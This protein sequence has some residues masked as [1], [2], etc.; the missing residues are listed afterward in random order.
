MSA[1]GDSPSVTHDTRP[2]NKLRISRFYILKPNS[3]QRIPITL[4]TCQNSEIHINPFRSLERNKSIAFSKAA[5][6]IQN[7]AGFTFVANLTND[8]VKLHRNTPIGTVV[9]ESQNSSP[10]S[11]FHSSVPKQPKDTNVVTSPS[12]SHSFYLSHPLISFNADVC[13]SRAENSQN[14]NQPKKDTQIVPPQTDNN[15]TQTE[16]V[17]QSSCSSQTTLVVHD[18]SCQTQTSPLV[19]LR[20]PNLCTQGTQSDITGSVIGRLDTVEM[21]SSEIIYAAEEFYGNIMHEMNFELFTNRKVRFPV[22]TVRNSSQSERQSNHSNYE[23]SSQSSTSPGVCQGS[24][25]NQNPSQPVPYESKSRRRERK[26]N[27]DYA[28]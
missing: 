9:L 17:I 24:D 18:S 25:V 16:M 3:M 20:E 28:T 11:E 5:V 21:L 15:G 22:P 6:S 12:P 27:Q 7:G 26:E 23:S 14:E 19:T 10:L 4:N 2:D 1:H 8:F 13:T